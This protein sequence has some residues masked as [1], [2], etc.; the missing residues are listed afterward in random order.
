MLVMVVTLTPGFKVISPSFV[1]RARRK[2]LSRRH[3]TDSPVQEPVSSPESVSPSS[4]SSSTPTPEISPQPQPVLFGPS[5]DVQQP[6]L[7]TR[8]LHTTLDEPTWQMLLRHFTGLAK[9]I[10]GVADVGSAYVYEY[11]IG[12]LV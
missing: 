11:D 9:L 8:T 7:V 4:V 10:P 1:L 12:L 2:S 5:Q 6:S 3:V